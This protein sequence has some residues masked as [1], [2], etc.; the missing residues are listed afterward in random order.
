MQL[1]S[2]IAVYFVIWWICLL[3]V[4]PIGA[5]SQ[6]DAGDVAEGTD[7]GAPALLRIWPKLAITTLLALAVL[8]LVMWGLENPWLQRYIAVNR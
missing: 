6:H 4:L 8:G 7:P 3:M 5:H 1:F 2:W